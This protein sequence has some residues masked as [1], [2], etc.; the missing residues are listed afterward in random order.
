LKR[1]TSNGTQNPSERLRDFGIIG[2]VLLSVAVLFIV[3]MTIEQLPL[4]I[5]FAVAIILIGVVYQ[6]FHLSATASALR[7]DDTRGPPSCFFFFCW[8]PIPSY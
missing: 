7:S 5:A 8:Q 3:G 1:A 2:G 6:R 4:F